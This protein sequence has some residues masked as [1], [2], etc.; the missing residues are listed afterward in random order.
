MD[1]NEYCSIPVRFFFLLLLFHFFLF[2]LLCQPRLCH[3]FGRL[4]KHRTLYVWMYV[5]VCVCQSFNWSIMIYLIIIH[6]KRWLNYGLRD[7]NNSN[8]DE[9]K[10]L[11]SDKNNIWTW[12]F[13]CLAFG[14]GTKGEE[15]RW[16]RD[17]QLLWNSM[18]HCWVQVFIIIIILMSFSWNK[19]LI[20][21]KEATTNEIVEEKKCGIFL[22]KC[23]NWKFR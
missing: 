1:F 3:V 11:N 8:K 9:R 17:D 4:A 2:L 19:R 23:A 12:D 10:H 15:P 14:C 16:A 20:V 13:C 18:L 21:I 7:G 22:M 6:N 5:C